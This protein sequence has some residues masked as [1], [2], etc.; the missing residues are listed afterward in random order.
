M[1]MQI[2]EAR[3][4][5]QASGVDYLC[6][7]GIVNIADVRNATFP[8]SDVRNVSRCAHSIDDGA[9]LDDLVELVSHRTLHSKTFVDIEGSNLSGRTKLCLCGPKRHR[10]VSTA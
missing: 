7:A 2:N 6:V 3:R 5:D 1:C 4:D 9:A 8:D 10:A